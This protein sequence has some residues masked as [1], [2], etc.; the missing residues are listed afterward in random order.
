MSRGRSIE[1]E[2]VEVHLSFAILREG[3]VYG[4][5]GGRKLAM[6]V[7]D[8]KCLLS[9]TGRRAWSKYALRRL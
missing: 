3:E 7:A 6:I 8:G 4:G 2:A 1:A 9:N 5:G